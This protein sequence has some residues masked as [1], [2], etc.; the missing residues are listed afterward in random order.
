MSKEPL[1]N[2]VPTLDMLVDTVNEQDAEL[3]LS[4]AGKYFLRKMGFVSLMLL[5]S[6][7]TVIFF[8]RRLHKKIFVTHTIGAHP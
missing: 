5:Y 4:P 3:G 8:F 6:I 7:V 1:G 2:N